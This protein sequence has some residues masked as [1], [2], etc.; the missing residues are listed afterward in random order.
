MSRRLILSDR[1]ECKQAVTS[2]KKVSFIRH[3]ENEWG[4][5][6]VPYDRLQCRLLSGRSSVQLRP[7]A[8][9]NQSLASDGAPLN[10][11]LS[12]TCLILGQGARSSICASAVQR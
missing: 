10:R 3:C 9:Q 4:Y 1:P 8:P 11:A 7:G 2:N 12:N 6:S 5:E